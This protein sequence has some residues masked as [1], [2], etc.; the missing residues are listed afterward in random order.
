M[1]ILSI[2]LCT[3]SKGARVCRG[4]DFQTPTLTPHILNPKTQGYT[5]TPVM[6]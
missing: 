3:L 2:N 1:K 5:L 4:M 6:P